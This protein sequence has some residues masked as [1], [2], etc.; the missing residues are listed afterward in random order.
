MAVTASRSATLVYEVDRVSTFPT[1]PMVSTTRG[2]ARRSS[3]SPTNEEGNLAEM[4]GKSCS[5]PNSLPIMVS[6]LEAGTR[7]PA[8]CRPVAENTVP[9][10]WLTVFIAMPLMTSTRSNEIAEI[11][12]G[13][14]ED[15]VATRRLDELECRLAAFERGVHP[16][17]D[18]GDG[19][20]GGGSGIDQT[21]G[22]VARIG[23]ERHVPAAAGVDEDEELVCA[24]R[25]TGEG[26]VK[27]HAGERGARCLS[28]EP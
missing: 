13:R 25:R 8:R 17:F 9:S 5:L 18:A 7:P 22:L 16:A 26:L 14:A 11:A 4:T 3:L 24:P 10:G 27:R 1:L 12:D 6:M 15:D 23:P 2:M 28:R 21:L 20:A 19:A